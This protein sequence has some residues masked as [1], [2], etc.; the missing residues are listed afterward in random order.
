[1]RKHTQR[2]LNFIPIPTSFPHLLYRSKHFHWFLF[3]L[4]LAFFCTNKHTHIWL[5]IHISISFY[6]YTPKQHTV[7]FIDFLPYNI[8]WKSVIL[9]HA[10]LP[11]SLSQLHSTREC[12]IVY[13]TCPSLANSWM[14][15]NLL[16]LQITLQQISVLW[17]APYL[18]RCSCSKL[19]SESRAKTEPVE[20]RG[21][22]KTKSISE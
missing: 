22:D 11:D 3:N 12:T 4:C 1:M 13:Q 6:F 2:T 20:R 5:F 14:I 9:A 19:H 21:R 16:L 7:I 15:N 18:W 10:G 17:V 8:A